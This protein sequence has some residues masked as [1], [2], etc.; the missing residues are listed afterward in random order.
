MTPSEIDFIGRLVGGTFYR[1]EEDPE[2]GRLLIYGSHSFPSHRI[3]VDPEKAESFLKR[4]AMEVSNNAR[5]D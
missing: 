5:A 2:L 1:E 3:T 4:V